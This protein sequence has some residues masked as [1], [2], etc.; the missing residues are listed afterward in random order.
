M[1]KTRIAQKKIAMTFSLLSLDKKTGTFAGATATGN[2][3]VGGW[4]LR[5]HPLAGLTASQGAEPS[6]IWG[7]E[8]L[9]RMREGVSAQRAIEC[10]TAS[11][12][13]CEWR[14]IAA[15]DT[16]GS[17]ATFSGCENGKLIGEIADD[18]VVLAG[19]ILSN[20][21]VLT[22]MREEFVKTDLEIADRLI[23]ALRAGAEVG[24]DSRGLM[25]A[26]M[27]VLP[28]DLPPMT[29]RVDFD[30]SPID[31]LDFLLQKTRDTDYSAWLKKLPTHK[32]PHISDARQSA[33]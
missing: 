32:Y 16:S 29:L 2:L 24:G 3:C 10:V 25:S 4:V 13:R 1:E 22:C 12:P 30:E 8:V 18:S 11:D 23:A 14:Q 15:L 7:E 27:L 19:N 28:P 26:A 17:T 21:R 31:R 9:E 33:E 5:G 6:V 20:D